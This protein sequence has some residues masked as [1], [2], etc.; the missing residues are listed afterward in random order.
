MGVGHSF[1]F[2]EH[3]K[4]KSFIPVSKHEY[5]NEQI[6]DVLFVDHLPFNSSS[7]NKVAKQRHKPPSV[8]LDTISK[9]VSVSLTEP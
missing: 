5:Y 7:R 1:F 6:P 4:S 9:L 2:T 8:L 3:K